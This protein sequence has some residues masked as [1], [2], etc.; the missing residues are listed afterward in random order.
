MSLT[1]EQRAKALEAFCKTHG[2]SIADMEMLLAGYRPLIYT[3]E[4]KNRLV[5]TWAD[6]LRCAEWAIEYATKATCEPSPCS[7]SGHFKF[8]LNG[9]TCLM[10]QREERLER[11]AAQA[12]YE[13]AAEICDKEADNLEVHAQIGTPLRVVARRIRKGEQS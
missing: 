9:G 12:A 7:V 4:R 3:E 10:C 13:R 11:E 2:V 5:E 8:Q 6:W 1:D